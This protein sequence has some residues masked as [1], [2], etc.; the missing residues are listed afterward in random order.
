MSHMHLRLTGPE[1]LAAYR[2]PKLFKGATV[3]FAVEEV[4]KETAKPHM[5]VLVSLDDVTEAAFR[6][7]LRGLGLTGNGGFS[8]SR[9]RKTVLDLLCYM[10]KGERQ[11]ELP[12]VVHNGSM[13]KVEELHERYWKEND[14]LRGT[15]ESLVDLL[16]KRTTDRSTPEEMVDEVIELVKVTGKLMDVHYCV[17]VVRTVALRHG[18]V[19]ARRF[20][21][22]IL[23]LI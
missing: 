20:A 23:D 5:H 12:N 14:R 22:N 17:K 4:G 7:R 15:K 11:G 16:F 1:G 18:C 6:Q 10:C 8:L 2:S 21:Q 9:L 13:W 3:V 19:W